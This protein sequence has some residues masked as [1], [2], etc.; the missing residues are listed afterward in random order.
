MSFHTTERILLRVST[1]L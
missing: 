1:D